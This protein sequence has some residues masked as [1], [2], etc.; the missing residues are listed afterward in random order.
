MMFGKSSGPGQLVTEGDNWVLI[1]FI[2][3]EKIN[4]AKDICE[5]VWDFDYSEMTTAKGSNSFQNYL[6][7]PSWMPLED[8]KE[9]DRWPELRDL[10]TELVQRE[11]INHGLL[12]HTWTNLEV[13]GAWTVT[14][15]EG[16]YHTVHDHGTGK[17]STVTYLDVP[18]NQ[19][20][21]QGDI[22]FVLH[23]NSYNEIS[24]PMHRV[25]TV[26]PQPG[27]I[28]MFPSW[29][30]HG[31]YPQGKGL[32]RTLNVDFTGYLD[33]SL[34]IDLESRSSGTIRFN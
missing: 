25:F 19:E 27:M 1:D 15:Q 7:N 2:G 22:F 14:G 20:Y 5:T 8:F 16:S 6:V 10:W 21:P 12:P 34:E 13:Q 26:K 3:E 33:K 30:V 18:D 29:I 31:V 28:I 23:G 11:I 24:M 17:I 9:S 32:R 4:L